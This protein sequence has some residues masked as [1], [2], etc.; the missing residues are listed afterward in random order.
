MQVSTVI[1]SPYPHRSAGRA[2]PG[3]AT[4]GLTALLPVYPSRWKEPV[5]L[6]IEA[7]CAPESHTGHT[8]GL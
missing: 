1:A 4:Q 6:P 7:W 5:I 2:D 8:E 3:A